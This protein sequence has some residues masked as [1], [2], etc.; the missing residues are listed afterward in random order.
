MLANVPQ[1]SLQTS[2]L[3]LLALLASAHPGCDDPTS[4]KPV[5]QI[6]APTPKTDAALPNTPSR[7]DAVRPDAALPDAPSRPDAGL[8]AAPSE[9]LG[10]LGERLG[11]DPRWPAQ[12][13]TA[14]G[15]EALGRELRELA[16]TPDLLAWLA[17]RAG[18]PLALNGVGE[19]R[20]AE[21]LE[22]SLKQHLPLLVAEVQGQETCEARSRA[23]LLGGAP[24]HH[25]DR[26]GKR[27]P[28]EELSRDLTR[29]GLGEEGWWVNC[30]REGASGYT[31]LV[32]P[33]TVAG[34]REARIR[35]LR[36]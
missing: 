4:P 19:V 34:Q 20:G 30:H 18:W 6:S 29:L 3:A 10:A 35:A 21:G 2:S 31:L 36:Y 24:F 28:R 9:P 26:L 7:P 14:Q 15:A 25:L 22:A 27:A 5:V 23:D 11:A 13:P 12:P 32:E 33:I 1:R 16:P 8:A 17:R